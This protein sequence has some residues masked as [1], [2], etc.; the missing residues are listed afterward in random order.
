MALRDT[1]VFAPAAFDVDLKLPH[2]IARFSYALNTQ[3][4]RK[5]AQYLYNM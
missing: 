5:N 2:F 3:I 1:P 4:T